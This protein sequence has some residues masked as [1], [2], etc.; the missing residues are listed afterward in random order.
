MSSSRSDLV[1]QFVRSSVCSS[2]CLSVVRPFFSSSVLGVCSAFFLVLKSFNI[3]VSRKFKGCLKFQGCFKEVLRVFT[4]N[5]K[6]VQG[7]FRSVSRKF[8]ECFFQECF[9]EISRVFQDC[10]KGV[11]SKIEGHFNSF[12]GGLRVFERSLKG[13]LGQFKCCFMEVSKKF[14]GCFMSVSRKFKRAFQDGF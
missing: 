5:F 4:G 10:I 9:K 1:T 2:V 3:R 8:Q 14:Q 7:S 12:K 6:G 13:V 11:S